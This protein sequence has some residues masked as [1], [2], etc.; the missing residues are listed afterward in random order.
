MAG[1]QHDEH[2]R[3]HADRDRDADEQRRAEL[4]QEQPQHADR[5]DDAREQ[6][7][8]D[9]PDRL[10]DEDRRIERLLDREAE[11]RERPLAKLPDLFLDR[12]QRREHVGA[13]FLQD[14]DRDRRVVVLHR[15]RIAVAALD[16]DRGDVGQAHRPAIA[17]VE[18]ELAEVFGPVAAREAQRVLAPAELG[19]AAG[20]VVGAAGDARDRGDR[21]AEFRGAVRVELD[22]KLVGCAGIDVDRADARDRLDARAHQVLDLAPIV[23]D[24]ARRPGLQLHEEPGQRLVRAAAAVLAERNA[25]RVGIA[26][27]R[28]ELV[29]A[30]DDVDQ[31]AAHVRADRELQVDER[32]AGVREGLDLL[33]AREAA[34]R[35][36]LR[37]DQFGFDFGRR[38][39]AP[40]GEDRD[41]RLVD[42]R[43]ELHREA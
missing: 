8:G 26:R 28:R 31:R 11:V 35:L 12:V 34:Q 4:A 20:D 14:L 39:R 7:A 40:A 16:R 17:P 30:R 36:L 33:Q 5:E 18:H 38:R 27:Q 29:H 6:V 3:E 43:E 10:V 15:E 9:Q 41:D 2:G 25:R 13:G 21:D 19:E 24:R 22:A 37:L 23:L 32:A 42:V 1:H